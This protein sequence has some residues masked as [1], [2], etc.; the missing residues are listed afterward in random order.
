MNLQAFL[1]GLAI[2]LVSSIVG[3]TV[4]YPNRAAAWQ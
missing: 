1:I 3:A 2:G 4:E